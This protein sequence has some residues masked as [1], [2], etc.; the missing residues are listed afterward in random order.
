MPFPLRAP[1]NLPWRC[2]ALGTWN[3]EGLTSARKKLEIGGVLR[4]ARQ[5]I[6]AFQESHEAAAS[7]IDVPGYRWFS[8]PEIGKRKGG[9]GFLVLNAFLPEV[10]VCTAT[11]HSCMTRQNVSDT[12]RFGHACRANLYRAGAVS[13][14]TDTATV[15]IPPLK[16]CK[17]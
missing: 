9:V 14:E 7:H 3:V 1:D 6:A 16:P 12:V 17:P 15:L 5:H 2:L 11:H 13:V 10:E 4:Q 8:S